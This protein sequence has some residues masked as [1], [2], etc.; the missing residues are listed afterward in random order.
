MLF[1]SLVGWREYFRLADTPGR[2]GELDRW[3]RHRLRALHLK[4]WKRGAVVYRELRALGATADQAALAASQTRRWWHNS[5][6]LLNSAL[7]TRYFDQ[8]GVPRLA[9]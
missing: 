7:P 4:H 1:R 3:L 6:L 5:G 9:A 2:F 8:I